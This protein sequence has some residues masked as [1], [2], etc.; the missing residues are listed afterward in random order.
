MLNNNLPWGEGEIDK[1]NLHTNFWCVVGVGK[2]GCYVKLEVFMI[3]DY[4]VPKFYH[5]RPLLLECL[6]GKL[7]K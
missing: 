5:Q 1:G 2:L 7:N 4:R 3:G 6:L